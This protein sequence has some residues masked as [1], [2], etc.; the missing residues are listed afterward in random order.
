[1]R[2]ESSAP[3]LPS[4]SRCA[5]LPLYGFGHWC[6]AAFQALRQA[7]LEVLV[8]SIRCQG[9]HECHQRQ[10]QEPRCAALRRV[11]LLG[12]GCMQHSPRGGGGGGGGSEP[13]SPRRLSWRILKTCAVI[14]AVVLC[15]VAA[16]AVI[17]PALHAFSGCVS[18][19]AVRRCCCAPFSQGAQSQGRG[20]YTCMQGG[21]QGGA[22]ARSAQAA[23]GGCE[24]AAGL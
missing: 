6:Q 23:G 21:E 20:V 22:A 24:A 18:A 15:N 9:S 16:A 13:D 17:I 12:L 7:A 11:R 3:L 1:M 8:P 4:P 19:A 14:I 2:A 5:Q 10:Y